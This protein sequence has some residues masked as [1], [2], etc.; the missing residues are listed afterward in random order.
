MTVSANS[1]GEISAAE[2]LRMHTLA[3]RKERPIANA[4][5]LKHCFVAVATAAS[6]GDVGAIDGR[7]SIVCRQDRS[8][9]AISGVAVNAGCGL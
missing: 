4:A 8:Q 7:L 9:V 6:L 1:G 2:G 5:P 3:I